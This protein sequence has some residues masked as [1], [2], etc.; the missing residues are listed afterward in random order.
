MYSGG[1]GFMSG[2][3]KYYVLGVGWTGLVGAGLLWMDPALQTGIFFAGMCALAVGWLILLNLAGDSSPDN[4]AADAAVASAD[5]QLLTE[6][7]GTLLKC[8]QEFGGQ[9]DSMRD[10]LFRVQ[11]LLTEAIAKLVVSFHAM[12]DQSKHQQE[13]GLQIISQNAG[14]GS[15][16][17]FAGFANQTSDTLRTFVDSVVDNSK[18]AMELVEMTDRIS[19]QVRDILGMLGEIEGISKQTNLLALNAAIEAARAGEAGR[20]F[21]VVADEVRDLSGRTAHFSQQIRGRVGSMQKSID[22]AGK[23]INKLAAQD[24]TF[25]LKS[26]QDV[27][28]AMN[29]VEEMNTSTGQTVNKLQHIAESME[30]N[31]GQ[32]VMSL[33]FQDMVTQLIGHVSKRLDEMH[34]I[35]R[36]IEGVSSVVEKNAAG[37]AP[38]QAD[39][40]R[41]HLDSVRSLLEQIHGNTNNNPVRQANFSSGEIDLF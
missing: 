34:G 9:F 37:F 23:A 3:A 20:G 31:V 13:L 1:V 26:K 18:L 24:M 19:T 11:Q 2:Q 32:A 41:A 4:S 14:D 5:A 36:E 10:E 28:D 16:T 29:H 27:E 35:M 25:A 7:G 40:L 21:A 39:R 38:G 22:D 17:S 8:G 33:Q 12:S 15:G 6:T 30:Q